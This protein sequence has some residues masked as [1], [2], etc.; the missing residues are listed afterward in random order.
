[1][2]VLEIWLVTECV[3]GDQYVKE[4]IHKKG[5]SIHYVYRIML[6]GKNL[7]YYRIKSAGMTLK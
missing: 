2:E 3:K 5:R 1:M 6:T 7:S 4:Q